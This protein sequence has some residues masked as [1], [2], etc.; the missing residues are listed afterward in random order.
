MMSCDGKNIALTAR[1]KE[2]SDSSYSTHWVMFEH[3]K[4][5]VT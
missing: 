5:K 1:V 3:T 2:K 4:L